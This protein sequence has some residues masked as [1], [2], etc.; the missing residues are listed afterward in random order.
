MSYGPRQVKTNLPYKDDVS[1]GFVLSWFDLGLIILAAALLAGYRRRI[2]A[3][4]RGFE[5]RNAQRRAEEA[6]ALFDRYA[7]YRQTVQFAEEQIEAVSKITVP[8]ER[9]G[10]PVSRYLFLG[11]Q[12]PTRA[13][14]EVA[15][16]EVVVEKAREFY[17]DLD[18]IYLSRGGSRD[19]TRTRTA[20]QD[21]TKQR[22]ETPPRR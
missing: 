22:S 17:K 12:Y 14:A 13:D 4:F 10:E 18:K 21:G 1:R 11:V 2:A 19:S 3:A 9:T 16:Y 15:R 8:D 5:A 6:R 20:L 7:H